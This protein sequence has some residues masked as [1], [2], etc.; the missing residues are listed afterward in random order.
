V[1]LE[2]LKIEDP[3]NHNEIYP[4][5]LRFLESVHK[6]GK[7]YTAAISSGTPSMQACW[8]LIAESG[9][10]PLKLVRSDDPKW[11]VK[12]VRPVKLSTALPKIEKIK[13]ENLE[14]KK[15]ALSKLQIKRKVPSV[16]IGDSV[17]NLTPME[18]VY[19]RFFAE[20]AKKGLEYLRFGTV[21]VPEVFYKSVCDFHR[22]SFPDA[23][24]ARIT[25]EKQK[26]IS[27]ST[28]RSNVTRINNKMKKLVKNE[29]YSKYYCIES[30]GQR[31]SKRYGV[32][33]PH[34]LINIK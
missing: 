33:L 32:S 34:Q 12:L 21:N 14:L 18:F 4:K 23:D 13:R 19:Y 22:D 25:L 26:H 6:Q 30:E 20:R 31:L 10:F 2:E 24:L 17:L 1:Y 29:F 5:L 9:A 7:S 28:F 8:I 11:G 15:S 3:T 16:Q 27:C